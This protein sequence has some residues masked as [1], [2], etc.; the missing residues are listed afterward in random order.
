[1]PTVIPRRDYLFYPGEARHILG[2]LLSGR[3][4]RGDAVARFERAFGEL[5]G[6][7]HAIATAT[8]R[9]GMELL[10][11]AHGL[12]P[13]DEVIVPAYTLMDL[14]AL[15]EYHGLAPVPVDVRA[16]SFTLDPSLLEAAVTRRTRAVIACHLFGLPFDVDAVRAVCARHDL[17]LIEDCAHAAGAT[18]KGAPVGALGHGGFFSLEVIKPVNCFGGG[19][20]T[21][22]DDA[23]AEHCRRRLETFPVPAWPVL[24]KIILACGEQAVLRSPVF[25]PMVGMMGHGWTKALLTKVYLGTHA[26][27]RADDTRLTNVQGR[28][29]MAQ[30]PGLA[31]RNR[32]RADLARRIRERLDPGITVQ[33]AD[34]PCESVSYFFVAH[35]GVDAARLRPILLREGID[36]GVG[37]EITDDCGRDPD[38][39]PVTADLTRSAIQV[40]LYPRLHGYQADRIAAAINRCVARLR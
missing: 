13:G 33:R 2:A 35:T 25:G 22:N 14:L 4:A 34:Y 8:G 9:Q 19:V 29:G 17:V 7:R 27:T 12:E 6:A 40:P 1:M 11:E 24:K 3:V 30:L 10:L 20:I 39:F 37:H 31:A 21:T 36:V 26:A 5:M 16:D 18:Y 23:V 15:L 28:V 32:R 38:R